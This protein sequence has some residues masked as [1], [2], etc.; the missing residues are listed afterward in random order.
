MRSAFRPGSFA[1]LGSPKQLARIALTVPPGRGYRIAIG[2]N[3][4]NLRVNSWKE[5]PSACGPSCA[6][7]AE[8]EVPIIRGRYGIHPLP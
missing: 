1:S 2:V 4:A 5:N 6:S 3:A 7:S 8:I